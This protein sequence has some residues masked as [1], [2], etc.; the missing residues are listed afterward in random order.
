MFLTFSFFRP[1]KV[2]E[3]LLFSWYPPPPPRGVL[4][5]GK[6]SFHPS[7]FC[8]LSPVGLSQLT[9]AISSPLHQQKKKLQDVS[10]LYILSWLQVILSLVFVCASSKVTTAFTRNL[11]ICVIPVPYDTV[12]YMLTF[13]FYAFLRF[14]WAWKRRLRNRQ[15]NTAERAERARRGRLPPRPDRRPRPWSSRRCFC[16]HLSLYQADFWQ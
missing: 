10:L 6:C 9:R 11:T 4:C 5:N 2:W 1:W 7:N 8:L 12:K 3:S 15:L 13:I 16:F 14:F